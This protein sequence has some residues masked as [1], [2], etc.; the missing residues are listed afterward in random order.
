MEFLRAKAERAAQLLENI[1]NRA[2]EV[3]ER[4][5][6]R[7][8]LLQPLTPQPA[9]PQVH[10]S[11]AVNELLE[12]S[13]CASSVE[14][15][16]VPQTPAKAAIAAAGD[17]LEKELAMRAASKPAAAVLLSQASEATAEA[18][19]MELS[20]ASSNSAVAATAKQNAAVPAA[21]NAATCPPSPDPRADMSCDAAHKA[22]TSGR[23]R[24][25]KHEGMVTKVVAT[26]AEA[27][28]TKPA[29]VLEDSESGTLAAAP[30]VEARR[31]PVAA[32][33][34][35]EVAVAF[36]GQAK[37]E[38]EGEG[39]ETAKRRAARKSRA[40]EWE[41]LGQELRVLA[42]HG[43]KLQEQF[44]A[45]AAKAHFACA[46]TPLTPPRTY[47]RSLKP[48]CSD[49]AGRHAPAPQ[50]ARIRQDE[51]QAQRQLQVAL[52]AKLSAEEAIASAC[53]QQERVPHHASWPCSRADLA[54]FPD[55][56]V[57]VRSLSS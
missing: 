3:T 44:G 26:V 21:E 6:E 14:P 41:T 11:N 56:A 30:G 53:S 45:T 43:Q 48:T 27:K 54:R 50:V 8:G 38:S 22:L 18:L 4:V 57:L 34:A 23:D 49:A 32:T 46:Q 12:G 47:M 40:I 31:A 51:Q 25:T 17:I 36:E 37:G 29:S 15:A 39:E 24:E 35:L 52:A 5:K 9:P 1:D 13:A 19:A 55:A 42:M 20:E 16:S 28:V 2:G 10:V 33:A 7:A